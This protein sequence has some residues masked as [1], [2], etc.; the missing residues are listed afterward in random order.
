MS[1]TKG[2]QRGPRPAGIYEDKLGRG[3]AQADK[4]SDKC[5]RCGAVAGSTPYICGP[6]KSALTVAS[7]HRG[8]AADPAK[9][10]KRREDRAR[11]MRQRRK[12]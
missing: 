10:I 8:E 3:I 12:R 11:Y 5:S 6:C 9:L 1:A 2:R 7:R 4:R